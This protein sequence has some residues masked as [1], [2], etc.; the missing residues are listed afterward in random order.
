VAVSERL[1]VLVG[2][3]LRRGGLTL[4]VA[5]SCTGGLLG[6]LITDVPGSS[7][8]F[9]GGVIAYSDDVKRGLLKVPAETIQVHGAVSAESALAMAR[10][11]RELVGADLAVSITGIAGPNG[12]TAAKPVGTTY[13][14][15]V[16]SSFERIEHFVWNGDRASNKRQS[17]DAALGMVVEYV[18]RDT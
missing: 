3:L 1:E 5:E 11:V 10:G 8:Y 4:A 15:L 13:I 17:A 16:S 18:K 7:D 14:A 9:L 12:G 2:E 6:S